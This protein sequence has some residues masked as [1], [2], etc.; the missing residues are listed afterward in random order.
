MYLITWIT[1][2]LP[3][4]KGWMAELADLQRTSDPKVNI[5]PASSLAQDRESSPVKDQ[6][7]TTVLRRQ[8]NFPATALSLVKNYTALRQRHVSKQLTKSCYRYMKVQWLIV[9]TATY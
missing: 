4:P 2:H 3:T 5:R 6:R 8:F 7:S 9:K 1:T